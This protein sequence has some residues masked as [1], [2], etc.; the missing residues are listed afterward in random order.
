MSNNK[1][2]H[3]NH[4]KSFFKCNLGSVAISFAIMVPAMLAFMVVS[5]EHTQTMRNRARL[6]EATNEASLAIIA[7]NNKNIDETAIKN[8]RS[9]A[10]NYINYFSSQKITDTLGD[11]DSIDVEYN[12]KEKVYSIKYKQK[13]NS[14]ITD[15]QTGESKSMFVTNKSDSYG[16]TKK[17]ERF[18]SFDIAFIADFSGSATC[19]YND[20]T[21]ND[22][23]GTNSSQQRLQYMKA[24]IV[25][26]IDKFKGDSKFALVPYD[27]GVPVQQDTKNPAGGESYAC[28]VMYKMKSPYDK[29]DYNFWANKNIA[30]SKWS[31]LKASGEINDFS[32]YNYFTK[33][34]NTV[35]YYLDYF[36]Y[37]YYS[38][39]IGPAKGLN[40]DQA[41]VNS[42]LCSRR[43]HVD[44][45]NMG[46]AKY[47]CGENDPN[48]PLSDKNQQ[49]IK[50]QY[51]NIVQLYDY[52]FSGDYPD[53][54]YSF[55]NTKTVDVQGTIDTLFS[56][57]N[58]NTITFNRPISPTVADFSPFLGMCQSP[59][60]NN[61]IMSK[62]V[63]NMNSNFQRFKE[64]AKH[65]G[66]FKSSPHLVPFSKD[67]NHNLDLLNY[68]K[69]GNWQ[70][71]GGTD[72]ITALLRAV[73][74]MAKGESNN[75]MIIIIT[76]GK[77]DAGADILR[78]NF[79]DAGVCQAIT[80]GLTSL[81][82]Q[83]NGYINRAAKTAMIHYIKLDPQAGNS[84]DAYGKWFTKCM[85]GNKKYVH[86]ANDYKTLFDTVEKIIQTETGNFINKGESN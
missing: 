78:D 82:N 32:S 69:N 4:N 77:D 70:P 83:K 79:L 58:S 54:H 57:I 75:K 26:I 15:E 13:L 66:T 59:L 5:I 19:Q 72:T 45:L 65:I 34:E 33:F 80:S 11:G 27:I 28:S 40:N 37:R 23:L 18:D 81:D 10:M 12:T 43:H 84:T 63:I 56:G 51:G 46:S 62:D 3:K 29:I 24:A 73:P 35:N 16:N 86:E 71:G 49:I 38:Q 48:Y 2:E 42:G 53:V 7:L 21:C 36:N 74:V 61:N 25:D 17:F 6:S 9:M 22:Y 50:K 67:K 14:Q 68:I 31:N 47:A 39:I 44:Q 76:D 30:Y 64:T 20:S 8:N 55:A 41:L 85:N 1:S 60:Y 52:M